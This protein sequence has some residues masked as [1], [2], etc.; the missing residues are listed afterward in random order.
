MNRLEQIFM[1]GGFS[2]KPTLP[3]SEF[4]TP[5]EKRRGFSQLY[6]IAQK[7]GFENYATGRPFSPSSLKTLREGPLN[8]L[9]YVKEK[10]LTQEEREEEFYNPRKE[11]FAVGAVFEDLLR[12]DVQWTQDKY[13]V[14]DGTFTQ[15]AKSSARLE[16]KRLIRPL[17]WSQCLAMYAA[18]VET[19]PDVLEK[20]RGAVFEAPAYDEVQVGPNVL[21]V[22]GFLDASRSEIKW[23]LDIKTTETLSKAEARIF[24]KPWG[25]FHYWLQP[26]IYH[27][28]HNFEQFDFLFVSKGQFPDVLIVSFTRDQC[29]ELLQYARETVLSD[30]C[31]YLEHGFDTATH[32]FKK[33]YPKIRP[34]VDLRL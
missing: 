25:M 16:G 28:R 34:T 7:T 18:V 31:F 27:N 26:A 14:Q 13:K 21:N 10:P 22:G 1:Q 19:A 17:V 8:Y 20:I 4:L 11:H 33:S 3:P 5:F 24:D 6:R 15:A 29:D 23:A 12:Y 30:A 32:Q 9:D 2:S